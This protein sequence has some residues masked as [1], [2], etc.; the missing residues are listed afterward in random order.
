MNH[1]KLRLLVL[2]VDGTLLTSGKEMSPVVKAALRR[3]VD[4]GLQIALATG[5]MFSAIEQ[6]VHEFDLRGPQVCNNGAEVI[7]PGTGRRLLHLALAPEVTAQLIAFGRARRLTVVLFSADRVLGTAHTPD[8]WL[9]ERNGEMVQVVP[10]SVFLDPGAPVEKLLYLARAAPERIEQ[11]RQA[12]LAHWE[13]RGA[14]PFAA[15]VSERGIL[16]FCHPHAEKLHAVRALCHRLD[17]GLEQVAAV[18][19]GE[20]DAALVAAAGFGIAMGNAAA[21]TRRGA[22]LVV[23]DNDHD[24]AAEAI[25]AVLRWTGREP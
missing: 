21:P 18:G 15:Q 10:D 24:G 17:M 16:N 9:I 2:D 22:D 25:R 3:A 12:L 13:G 5:R 20:N 14:P 4:A 8:D 6:W 11:T 19:D 23:A 1:L 7:E